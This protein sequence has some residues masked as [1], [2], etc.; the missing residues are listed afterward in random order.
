MVALK[1]ER[2]IF[3][4]RMT[5]HASPKEAPV[6][7]KFEQIFGILKAAF[8]NKEAFAHVDAQ[9]K[10]VPSDQAAENCI[11]I[12]DIKKSVDG[13]TCTILINRG[14]PDVAHPSFINPKAQTVKHVPPGRGEVQ[15]WSAHMV[16]QSIANGTKGH[17]AAFERM[18]NVSS[19]LVQRYID[20]LVDKATEGKAEFTYEKPIKKGKNT[21]IE[22][23]PYKLRL[24]INRVP[25]DDLVAD[26]KKGRLSAIK[27]IR[28]KPEYSG[29]GDPSIVSSISEVLRIGTKNVEDNKALE[30]INKIK[31]WGKVHDYDEV[32]FS[33]TELPGGA[34]AHP[35]FDIEKL[36]AMDTI[37][38]RSH[39]LT[40]FANLLET[41][42]Q[43]ID[44][45]IA[46]KMTA[47]LSNESLWQ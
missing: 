22:P 11:F 10:V 40:G 33:I 32:Q 43:E 23:R 14:D 8:D 36:D 27:L 3:L 15:G 4:W 2:R 46:D 1:N 9:G 45:E 21:V 17:R 34:S 47:E 44:G 30:Y 16:I 28:T 26:V 37:Y 7:V 13:K 29:P 38:S 31:E 42:Y 20:A 24:S 6:D 18:Q 12:A 41:C 35:R 25:S 19:T 5:P 39:R